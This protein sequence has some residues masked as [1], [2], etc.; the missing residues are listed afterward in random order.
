MT[1]YGANVLAD[2]LSSFSAQHPQMHFVAVGDGLLQYGFERGDVFQD[3]FRG[4]FD[5]VVAVFGVVVFIARAAAATVVAVAAIIVVVIKCF[6]IVIIVVI[7]GD[8]VDVIRPGGAGVAEPAC[9]A[10]LTR[11]ATFFLG[12]MLGPYGFG[13]GTVTPGAPG[14]RRNAPL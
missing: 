2:R 5:D 9:R 3:E 13:F 10:T 7:N 12:G 11:A 14:S 4:E 6:V 1:I 8:V